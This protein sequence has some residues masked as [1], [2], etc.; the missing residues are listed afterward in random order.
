MMP[1]FGSI[2]A[3]PGPIGVT[4]VPSGSLDGFGFG[5][6]SIGLFGLVMV[7]FQSG[8]PLFE[9]GPGMVGHLSSS[10]ST[11]SLSGSL[12]SGSLMV[13][14]KVSTVSSPDLIV[15]VTLSPALALGAGVNTTSPFGWIVAVPCPAGTSTF[16]PPG[17]FWSP[18]I[19][20][21][22]VT[23]AVG[24]VETSFQSGTGQPSLN[25]GPAVFGH[26]SLS[27]TT[28]SPSGSLGST[29]VTVMVSIGSV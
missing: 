12:A 26:L 22:T 29:I 4:V 13:T 1:V 3:S 19:V 8:Q 20:G 7:S 9:A 27:P 28:P 2:L 14:T 17:T 16:K 24:T 25:A 11:P 15:T 18:V 23:G 5:I 21:L 10:P 6:S